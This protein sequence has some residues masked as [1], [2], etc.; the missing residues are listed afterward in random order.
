MSV[1]IVSFSRLKSLY[2]SLYP[3]YLIHWLTHCCCSNIYL[4]N[5]SSYYMD[6]H[7][8][9]ELGWI[10]L[11][12]IEAHCCSV[13]NLCP[14][15]CDSMDGSTPGFLVLHCL[16][17]YAQTHV[18]WV[19]DVIQPSHPLLPPSPFAFRVF[20][21]E[22]TLCIR[23][24]K[25]WSFSFSISPSSEYSRLISSKIDWFDLFDLQGTLNILLQNH[26]SKFNS[27]LLN[28]LCGPT[29]TSV[30]DYLK[31]HTFDYTDLC[32]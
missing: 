12:W 7:D 17:E 15:L 26:N 5:I 10:W 8:F 20:S 16:L 4:V 9:I 24:P 31:N 3:R 13:T 30:H 19:S 32:Q 28:L 14:T 25:Y 29:L 11:Q 6:N 23:W 21:S 27:L 1:Q 22:S 18:H 2:M